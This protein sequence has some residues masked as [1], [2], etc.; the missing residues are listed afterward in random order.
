MAAATDAWSYFVLSSKNLMASNT[1]PLQE[2]LTKLGE[3]GWEMVAATSTVK[4]WFNMSGND[5]LFVFKKP[6]AGH[7]PP[8]PTYGYTDNVPY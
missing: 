6:G 4:T 3:D 2:S 5:L 1:D 8:W 7:R